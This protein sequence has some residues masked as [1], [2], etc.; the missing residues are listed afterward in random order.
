[1]VAAALLHGAR[2]AAVLHPAPFRVV[3]A[4]A[5]GALFVFLV[6]LGAA[7]LAAAAHHVDH[8]FL[9]AHQL[10]ADRI[11]EAG[12]D[13]RFDSLRDFQKGFSAPNRRAWKTT[14]DCYGTDV[15]AGAHNLQ[16]TRDAVLE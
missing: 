6:A 10:A 13:E 4:L 12:L 2:A 9:A 7:H 3:D 16:Q 1:A 5:E 8:G 14:V 11:D 15:C